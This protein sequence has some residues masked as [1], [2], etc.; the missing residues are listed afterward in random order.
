MPC[1]ITKWIKSLVYLIQVT[2]SC[3]WMVS[4]KSGLRWLFASLPGPLLQPPRNAL[5]RKE[6][7]M[8]GSPWHP[9][10]SLLLFTLA[11][12]SQEDPVGAGHLGWAPQFMPCSFQTRN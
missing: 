9:E 6:R 7:K 8:I 10:V 11:E 12:G 4:L 1:L 3:T 5:W 2:L